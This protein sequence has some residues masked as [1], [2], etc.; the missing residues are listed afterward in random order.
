MRKAVHVEKSRI[1]TKVRQYRFLSLLVHILLGGEFK[2]K[3]N[4]ASP[5]RYPAKSRNVSFIFSSSL[6]SNESETCDDEASRE[7]REF[8]ISDY[9]A[10][11][12]PRIFVFE[13][14]VKYLS[15]YSM[16]STRVVSDKYANLEV[17]SVAAQRVDRPIPMTC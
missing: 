11:R 12:N 8:K 2:K 17:P 6:L 9:R 5:L 3:K 10:C 13:V 7:Q 15:R 14:F 1:M 4:I 16:P